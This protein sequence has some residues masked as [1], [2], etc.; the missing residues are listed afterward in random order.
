VTDTVID[1]LCAGDPAIRW[2]TERDLLDAP[3]STWSS[4]R[5]AIE[6]KGWGKRILD[7]Q[8]PP[9]TW[10]GGLYSPKWTSTTYTLL[11]L[12]R[13][14]LANDDQRARNGCAQLLD[15]ATWVGG[16]VSY[17]KTHTYPELCVN[18]MVL[19]VCSYFALDDDRIDDMARML[20]DASLEGGGWNCRDRHGDTHPSFHTTISVLEGLAHWSAL[21]SSAEAAPAMADAHE[22]LLVHGLYRSHRTGEVIDR[23]WEQAHFPPRW[24]YDILRGLDHMR[25]VGVE[26]DPRAHDAVNVVL[27]ARTM[28]GRWPKGSQYGGEVFFPLEP[29]RVRGRWNTLRALRVLR[30]WDQR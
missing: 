21:R 12:T 24:H 6:S 8:D 5:R 27:R 30:W 20:V 14:G 15:R 28:D 23:T 10:G 9:G 1:W 11:L 29:G 13:F 4:S 18:A 3:E 25:A 19:A 22:M 16:G 7:H 26:P 2:Q 17:W